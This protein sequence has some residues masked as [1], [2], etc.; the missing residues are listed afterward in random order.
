[1]LCVTTRK[2]LT[3]VAVLVGIREMVPPVQ[4]NICYIDCKCGG[5]FTAQ[6]Y[7]GLTFQP[8]LSAALHLAVQTRIALKVEDVLCVNAV[9][10]MR[11]MDMSVQVSFCLP[12]YFLK[13]SKTIERILYTVL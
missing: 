13:P 6:S 3:T 4:V 11:V 1:M 2:D 12:S 8:S 10:G 9:P 5:I 7:N